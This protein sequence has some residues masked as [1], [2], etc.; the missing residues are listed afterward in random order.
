MAFRVGR[1][2]GAL[3]GRHDDRGVHVECQCGRRAA[4]AQGLESQRMAEQADPCP[5]PLFRQVQLEKSFLAQALVILDRVARGAVVLGRAGR[6]IR[7][8]FA[9]APLQPAVLLADPE[10]HDRAPF[11]LRRS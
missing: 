11:G 2:L 10:I 7:R 6:E 4:R 9:T 1:D 5:T 8:Q 3:Q